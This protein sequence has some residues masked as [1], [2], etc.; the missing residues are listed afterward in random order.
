MG[1]TLQA[2]DVEEYVGP[3]S[4]VNRTEFVRLL[5]E[6]LHKL[7]YPRI[8]TQLEEASVRRRGPLFHAFAL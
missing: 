4:M 3:R 8:A 6:A 7:G 1:A 5:E 2:E